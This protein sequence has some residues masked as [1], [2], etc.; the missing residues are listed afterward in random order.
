MN[1]RPGLSLLFKPD[2]NKFVHS[3]TVSDIESVLGSYKNLRS[4]RS[5]R[6]IFSIFFRW[7]VRHHYCLENPCDRL[8]K[9]PTE[10]SQIVALSLEESKRL[11]RVSREARCAAS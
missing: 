4:K 1:R 5:F 6:N 11:L 7:S 2:P 3:F 10:M 9:L 8:D